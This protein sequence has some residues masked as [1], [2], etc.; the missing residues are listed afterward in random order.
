MKKN[1]FIFVLFL[2]SS[3]L[4]F[5]AE[6]SKGEVASMLNTAAPSLWS[7]LSSEDMPE[8]IQRTDFSIQ[9]QEDLTPLWTVETIQPLYQTPESLTNT[10]FM[11]GRYSHD[12]DDDTANIGL[13]YRRLTEDENWLLGIN[14]FY[15]QAFEH[16]HERYSVGAEVIGRVM[17]LRT[18]FYEGISGRRSYTE[19]AGVIVREKALDGWDVEGQI[20]VPYMPWIEG[21]VKGYVWNGETVED[22]EGH[23]YSLI[24]NI[25]KNIVIE[26]G[27]SDDDNGFNRF[28][29]IKFTF[30]QPRQ[31]EYTMVDNFIMTDFFSERDL[32]KQTLA[33]VRRNNNIIV[34]QTRTGGTGFVVG[35]GL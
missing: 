9:F 16:R 27:Q 33:K 28:A 6:T 18:N 29:L 10:I 26:A 21:S 14:T 5:S 17:S 25:T 19:G 20:Q 12:N 24:M 15:D 32:K 1:I 31:V 30:G 34:E 23:G 22:L 2:F 7:N 13:G 35:R 11:Q 3:T 8:W 4:A